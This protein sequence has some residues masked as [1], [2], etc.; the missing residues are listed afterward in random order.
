MKKWIPVAAFGLLAAQSFALPTAV[1]VQ[2]QMGFGI[3]IGN[4]ME[5]PISSSCANMSCWGNQLPTK[6]FIDSLKAAGFTSVRIPAAWYTHSDPTT[7]TIHKS[8]LDSVKTVVDYVVDNGM[9]AFL[10]SHW[11]TGWLED[12]V[13]IPGVTKISDTETS[14]ADTANIRKLQELYWTQIAN[15]FKDYDEHLLFGSANEP[16]VNDKWLSD[17]QVKFEEQRMALLNRYHEAM[18]SAVRA[19]GGNNATRTIVVQAP[20]TDE[21]LMHALLKDNMPSDPAGTGYLMAEFHFYPYQF[22]LMTQDETWSKCF[23]YWGEGNYSTTDT[24][25][26]TIAGAYASEAYTDSVFA[27]LKADFVDQGIP[28]VIGEY[29][30]IKRLSAIN[31]SANLRLHLQSRASWYK[32]VNELSKAYGFVP[33]AWDTGAEGIDDNTIVR[34]QKETVGSILDYDVLNAMRIAWGLDSLPYSNIDSL[35]AWAG[36]NTNNAVEITYTS[37]RTDSSETGTMR[38][39]IGGKNWTGY[40]AVDFTAKVDV[41]S[42][43]PAGNDQYGWT[44]LSLFAMSGSSWKWSDYN[45]AETDVSTSW[46]HYTV[47]LSSSGLDL[48]DKSNVMAIGLNVYGTQLSG[49]VTI[50]DFT[51]VKCDGSG[52]DTLETF[53]KSLPDLEGIATGVL[54]PS[55]NTAAIAKPVTASAATGL[56]IAV[57]PGAVSATFHA[58]VP[59]TAT[60]SLMNPLGQSIA[61]ETVRTSLGT[62]TVQLSSGFHGPAILVVKQGAS[63]YTARITLK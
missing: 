61:S 39:N 14:T 41:Q 1:D 16:G 54:V 46:K 31:D 21:S 34:R 22:S 9:Y 2:K 43:G 51:L 48:A 35:V 25:H 42:N 30:A 4:T 52:S 55:T 20:R 56:R 45:F 27:M 12:N 17:G 49:T 7:G 44:S 60:V 15:K 53:N 23:Y 11:D 50:D 8:W 62:N 57:A 36:D 5:V 32:R 18:I 33:F 19:T 28:V 26:N 13:M 6:T 40:C 3:N 63:R 59:G 24:E 37:A 10:N 38:L 29:A 58:S 47:P